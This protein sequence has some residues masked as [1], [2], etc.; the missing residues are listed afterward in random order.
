[1]DEFVFIS[2]V[3]FPVLSLAYKS[4]QLKKIYFPFLVLLLIARASRH[5]IQI[6]TNEYIFTSEIIQ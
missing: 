2:E 6:R 5:C 4:E 1:M 3:C